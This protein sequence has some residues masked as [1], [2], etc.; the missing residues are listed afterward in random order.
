[1]TILV[2][3]NDVFKQEDDF[4]HFLQAVVKTHKVYLNKKA[5]LCAVDI[6]KVIIT[7]DVFK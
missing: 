3:A 4:C 6:S 5:V 1:M 7:N 2:L